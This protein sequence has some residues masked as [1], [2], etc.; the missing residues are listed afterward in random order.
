MWDLAV[1]GAD[2][3]GKEEV[4]SK[5]ETLNIYPYIKNSYGTSTN[6]WYVN[7]KVPFALNYVDKDYQYT[8]DNDTQG[9]HGSHVAGIAA[10][11]SY[12]ADGKGGYNN[13][14]ET[15]KVQGVAPDAQLIIMKVFGKTGGAYDSDYMVAIEDA[16]VLGCDV[17]NL[18]LGSDKGFTRNADYQHILDKLAQSDT[19]VTIAAGN[20]GTFADQSANGVPYIYADDVDMSVVGQPSTT[21][22]SLS[23]ASADN[24]GATSYYIKSGDDMIFYEMGSQ[25]DVPM[26][27]LHEIAGD[28]K[29]IVIDGLGTEEDLAAVVANEGGKIAENTIA[30]PTMSIILIIKSKRNADILFI[31]F[32]FCKSK[33][34]FSLEF[35]FWVK[36]RHLS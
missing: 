29:Y 25:S 21:T 28:Y 10:A 34:I 11:N 9:G 14:L 33:I 19:I 13:A 31:I 36:T 3:L 4:T 24:A 8:H 18:S 15:A 12:I 7:E 16:I 5:F 22:N 2:L 6:A 35:L 17:I 26:K 32:A 1:G 20:S 23:V 27:R 30:I